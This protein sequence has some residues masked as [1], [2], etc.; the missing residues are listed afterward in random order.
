MSTSVSNTHKPHK[1]IKRT[2]KKNSRGLK[3]SVKNR[4]RTR[5]THLGGKAKIDTAYTYLAFNLDMIQQYPLLNDWI[6]KNS[7]LCICKAV[8]TPS[9]NCQL[10]NPSGWVID[11]NQEIILVSKFDIIQNLYFGRLDLNNPEHF[12]TIINNTLGFCIIKK[13]TINNNN[14]IISI[15]DV[16]IPT[17]KSTGF[18]KVLFA[19]I[20]T[21]LEITYGHIDPILWLGIKIDNIEFDKICNLYTS[22][23]FAEPFITSIYPFGT[24]I[25]F[26]VLSL[27]KKLRYYVNVE[28]YTNM[29]F[30]KAV[31]MKD[32]FLSKSVANFNIMFDKTC[33]FK[34][35]LFPYL[36]IGGI[37]PIQESSSPSKN[38]REYSGNLIIINNSYENK[39]L[40]CNLSFETIGNNF[41]IHFLEGTTETVPIVYNSYTYHTHPIALYVENN[42]SIGTPSG[43]D[44]SAF[45]RG[46]LP[47]IN[48]NDGLNSYQ[49]SSIS[50]SHFV[51]AVEGIYCISFHPDF[52]SKRLNRILTIINNDVNMYNLLAVQINSQ[53]EFGFQNRQYNWGEILVD[54]QGQAYPEKLVQTHLQDYFTF[55]NRVNNYFNINGEIIGPIFQ[56][57]FKSWN[58]LFDKSEQRNKMFNIH[59]PNIYENSFVPSSDFK[60]IPNIYGSHLIEN[61]VGN[62]AYK[63]EYKYIKTQLEKDI[64][65]EYSQL[66]YDLV[67]DNS[68]DEYSQDDEDDL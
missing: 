11:D 16:C 18:G 33:L 23:G 42:C 57:D 46:L 63:Y 22:F 32:N 19:V 53:Y 61:M 41:N 54:Y 67:E 7:L 43:G 65:K 44:L 56:M 39:S 47:Y 6:H 37:T 36:T 5:K 66:T 52:I 68:P 35:R 50:H 26:P 14:N 1:K 58:D 30:N 27:S 51:I 31:Y 24:D 40:L 13:Q 55:F 59:I 2:N 9:E 62:N 17:P 20:M 10:S 3:R 60:I 8:G 49:R 45:F 15:Y 28:S 12:N 21:Y 48:I 34:L 4:K 29:V 64:D 25:G 38:H